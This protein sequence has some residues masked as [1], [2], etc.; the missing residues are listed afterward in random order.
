MKR[1]IVEYT[2]S[3][4]NGVSY[5]AVQFRLLGLW[6]TYRNAPRGKAEYAGLDTAQAFLDKQEGRWVKKVVEKV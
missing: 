6:I 2:H 3:S 4:P 1:R 5:Y